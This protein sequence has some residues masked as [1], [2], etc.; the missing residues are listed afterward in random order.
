MRNGS[1]SFF[2]VIRDNLSENGSQLLREAEKRLGQLS[3]ASELMLTSLADGEGPIDP[4]SLLLEASLLADTPLEGAAIPKAPLPEN[5]ALLSFLGRELRAFDR[6]GFTE[7]FLSALEGRLG[8]PLTLC[9]FPE[10]VRKKPRE[11]RVLYVK[12]AHADLA[13][14]GFASL[15]PL[16][17]P[18]ARPSFRAVCDDLEG[19][20]GDYAIL[21]LFSGGKEIPGV[22]SLLLEYGF[23]IA[24]LVL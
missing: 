23:S 21:P 4:A 13:L 10:G 24:A 5:R 2:D 15:L 19:E 9:D 16:A 12:N 22:F 17:R 11:E 14:H 20:I 18:L 8:R 7:C 6:V 3:E 1:L